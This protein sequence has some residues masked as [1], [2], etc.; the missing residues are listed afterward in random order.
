MK[1]IVILFLML[2]QVTGLVSEQKYNKK[3]IGSWEL[4]YVSYGF[5]K[6]P[7]GIYKQITKATVGTTTLIINE[8]KT[9]VLNYPNSKHLF[10]WDVKK[11][12]I[13]L[14]PNEEKDKS[15]WFDGIYRYKFNSENDLSLQKGKMTIYLKRV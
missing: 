13:T 11:K 14:I 3:L 6:M 8:D 15:E 9:A 5:E 10:Q 2:F 4:D 1:S 7:N 12:K